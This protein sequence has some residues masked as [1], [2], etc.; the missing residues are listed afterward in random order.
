L[1]TVYDLVIIL[2]K[3]KYEFC[4]A[5]FCIKRIQGPVGVLAV[6]IQRGL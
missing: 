5:I 2:L 3:L 6:I 4:L 1:C